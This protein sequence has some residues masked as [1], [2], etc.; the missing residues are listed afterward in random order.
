MLCMIQQQEASVI[1]VNLS[2]VDDLC[3]KNQLKIDYD[4]HNL[5]IL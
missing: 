2:S 5:L 4:I 1:G 3:K